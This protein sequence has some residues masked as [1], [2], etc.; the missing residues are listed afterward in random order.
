V[1][2]LPLINR[3]PP[4]IPPSTVTPA[5]TEYVAQLYE[6]IGEAIGKD[7]SGISDFVC[8]AKHMRLFDRSRLTFY[9]AEGLKELAR[10]QM[11]DTTYFDT[12][13]DEFENGLY[14]DY[15]TVGPTGLQRLVATVKAAQ[16]LQLGGHVLAHHVLANDREGICHHLANEKRVN[17]CNP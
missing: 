2:G 3:P 4:P 1:F 13:L 17:W 16:G 5:E 15:T 11:A 9:C 6:V 8:H 12:L 10:D 14:H 7:V